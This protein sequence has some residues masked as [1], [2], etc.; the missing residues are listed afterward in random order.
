[1]TDVLGSVT[2][3]NPI[4]EQLTGWSQD[5]ARGLPLERVFVIRNEDT[6]APVESPVDEVLRDGVV[7]GL[8]NHTV[9][10]GKDGTSIPVDDSGAPI[11]DENGELIGVVMVFHEIRE[12]RRMERQLK[13]QALALHDADQRKDRFLAM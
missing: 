1:T 10:I 7:V 2:F 3:M 9:L 11:R 5:E 12:Q 13:Q 4:A 6:G 8:A